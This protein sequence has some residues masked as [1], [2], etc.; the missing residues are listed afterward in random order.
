M[1]LKNLA[2]NILPPLEWGRGYS[3]GGFQADVIAGTIT[4]FITV[5]Q[6]IAYAFLTGLPPQVGLYTAMASLFM[7]GIFGGSRTL[8]VGPA[9]IISIM[10]LAALSTQAAPFSPEYVLLTAKLALIT[11][12]IL[13]LLRVVNFGAVISFLSH[14]V[15]VG[16]ITAAALLIII[17]QLPSMLGLPVASS[18]SFVDIGKSIVGSSSGLNVLD[19]AISALSIVLMLACK[20]ALRGFLARLGVSPIWAGSIVRSAPMLVVVFSTLAV[21][22]LSLTRVGHVAVVGTVPT[23]LPAISLV[24][25]D[26]ADLHQLGPSALLIAMVVFLESMSIATAVAGKRREKVNSNQELIAAGAT[27]IGASLVGGFPVAGSFGRTAVNF[28]AGAVTPVASIVTGALVVVTVIWF[29]PLFYYLPKAALSAIIVVSA[30]QL[31]E[32]H[33]IRKIIAFSPTDTITLAFTFLAVLIF[34][35]KLGILTGIAI[36]FVLLIRASNKPHIAVVGRW[37]NTEHFRNV[38]RYSVDT[39]PSVLAL[40]VDESFYFVNARYIEEFILNRVAESPEVKHVLLICAATNFIDS[41]GLEMLEQLYENL[42]EAGVT[43]HLSEVKGPVMDRLKETAFYKHM[44]GEVFFTTDIAIKAL[45]TWV[46]K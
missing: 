17:N 28:S 1:P 8:A 33:T 44:E 42:V 29:A 2:R 13:I 34:G 36:S 9:A 32:V 11:G 12:G 16:F 20:F 7:Y 30:A 4:L 41:S 10:T 22:T 40:R 6:S 25:I 24:S 37:H 21:G 15:I 39:I 31:I 26:F 27:N 38:L 14:A 19:L 46:E 5:P 43:L 3:L 23:Q 18:A 45:A 35:V